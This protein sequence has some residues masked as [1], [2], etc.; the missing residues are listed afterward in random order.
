MKR[1]FLVFITLSVLLSIASCGKLIELPSAPKISVEGVQVNQTCNVL[2]VEGINVKAVADGGILSL[3]VSVSSPALDA[4]AL[5]A[6]GLAERFDLAAPGKYEAGLKTLGLPC[7]GDVR[8]SK[9]VNFS[10]TGFLEY[11]KKGKNRTADHCITLELTDCRGQKCSCRII[12]HRDAVIG[13]SV[14]NA[15]MWKRTADI[16][17]DGS[18]P[19]EAS[20]LYRMKGTEEWK[21]AACADKNKR[22]YNP[23][24]LWN[25]SKNE[26]GLTVYSMDGY[27]GFKAGTEYEI[28]VSDADGDE[29]SLLE[30]SS[31]IGDELPN[32]DFSAWFTKNGK[33]NGLS[34][35]NAAPTVAPGGFWDSGNNDASKK[36]CIPLEGGG[37]WL[38][39]GQTM[40]IL[41]SGNIFSGDFVFN[42]LQGTVFFGKHFEWTARPTALVIRYSTSQ[43]KIDCE[44]YT[45]GKKGTQD[46]GIIQISVVD[47]EGQHP[48][49][50]GIMSAPSGTWDPSMQD[51]TEEGPVIGY[52]AKFIE[53]D[54]DGFVE[55]RIP[56]FWY[57]RDAECPLSSD[58][59]IVVSIANSY[60]GEYLT[61][62]SGNEMKI[63]YIGFEY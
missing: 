53:G 57:D 26:A 1:S 13:I 34:Y 35:P 46:K 24:P 60:L 23:E 42:G 37:A 16:I 11:F 27:T 44:K 28:L 61:G 52:A 4:E 62:C 29:L 50:S 9:S 30:Y 15:D 25:G 63:K 41:T 48:C 10:L 54:T 21:K 6:I 18:F 38:R 7:G 2:E 36:L 32:N 58:F 49:S 3:V 31:P 45:S 39:S 12:L 43:G 5:S 59:N 20:V 51:S 55:D 33:D 56:F 14:E 8:E 40:G 47:W 22:I 17:I 19:E